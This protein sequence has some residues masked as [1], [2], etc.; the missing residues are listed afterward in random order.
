MQIIENTNNLKMAACSLSHKFNLNNMLFAIKLPIVF[1]LKLFIFIHLTYS[2]IIHGNGD[3][4]EG[5][6]SMENWHGK[7][8]EE[9]YSEDGRIEKGSWV[10]GHKLGEFEITYKDGTTHKVMYKDNWRVEQ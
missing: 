7:G 9:Y 5:G 10:D 6:F 2:R 3:I 1:F 4:Y 8:E